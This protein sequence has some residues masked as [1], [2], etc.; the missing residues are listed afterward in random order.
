MHDGL[1][2]GNK[3]KGLPVS[4]VAL[5]NGGEKTPRFPRLAGELVGQVDR[6]VSEGGR[7]FRSGGAELAYRAVDAGLHVVEG[8]RRLLVQQRSRLRGE[9]QPVLCDDGERLFTGAAVR[10]G[11][12]AGDAVQGVAQNVTE[13]NAQ[14]PGRGAGLGKAP[15]LHGREPLADAVHLHDVRAAGG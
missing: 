13:D 5:Q 1:S 10:I 4:C 11:G 12:T 3:G 14:N 2:A 7:C 15:T 8:L 9:L 6:F